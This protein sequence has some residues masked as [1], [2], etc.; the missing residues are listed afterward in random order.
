[1]PEPPSTSGRGNRA[2]Q[3]PLLIAG[4]GAIV[5]LLGF[6]GL[7]ASIAGLLLVA[8]GTVLSAPAAPAGGWWRAL[9]IGALLILVGILVGL[10]VDTLGGLFTVIGGVMVVA[11]VALA[12]PLR[13]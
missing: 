3:V 13:S 7:I 10:L 1:M 12:F 6:F 2:L 11:A 8:A 9:A 4:A 5:V